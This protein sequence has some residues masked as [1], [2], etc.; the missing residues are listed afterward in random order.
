MLLPSREKFRKVHRGNRKGISC[1]GNKVNFGEYGLKAMTGGW[2]TARQIESARIAIT[3]YMKR[4]GKLW[5]RAFPHKPVTQ[6]PAETRQG[7]GKGS[8]EKHV[9]VVK[10]GHILFELAGVP[11]NVAREAFRLAG[12]KLPFKVRFTSRSETL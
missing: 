1:R 10:P 11:E 7:G 4:R 2:M 12:H 6:R 8:P 5:I 3:R 9:A